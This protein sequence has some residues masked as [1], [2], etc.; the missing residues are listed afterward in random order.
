MGTASHLY[1]WHRPVDGFLV[2][3]ED[4]AGS[5]F[6]VDRVEVRVIN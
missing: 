6:D 3:N 2:Y 5:D 4:A 1:R